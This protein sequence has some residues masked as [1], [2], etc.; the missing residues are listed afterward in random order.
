MSNSGGVYRLDAKARQLVLL[1]VVPGSLHIDHFP[2]RKLGTDLKESCRTGC[3]V[4]THLEFKSLFQNHTPWAIHGY[5]LS[6]P[7]DPGVAVDVIPLPLLSKDLLLCAEPILLVLAGFT[8]TDFVQL[9][10]S[11]SYDALG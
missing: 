3:A 4:L 1:E 8:T 9:I 2:G 6:L 5:P 10:G 11:R 7:A